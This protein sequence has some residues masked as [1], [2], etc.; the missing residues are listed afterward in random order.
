[1]LTFICFNWVVQPPPGVILEKK[2][3]APLE[4]GEEH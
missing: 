2:F 1:M 4:G 3:G